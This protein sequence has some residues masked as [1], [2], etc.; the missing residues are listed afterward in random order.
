MNESKKRA[1]N[2]LQEVGSA[3]PYH[4]FTKLALGYHEIVCFRMVENKFKKQKIEN[5]EETVDKKKY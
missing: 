5:S 1:F 4:G 2:K 3:K